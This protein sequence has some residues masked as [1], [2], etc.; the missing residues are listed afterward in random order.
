MF[1]YDIPKIFTDDNT[2][3]LSAGE[4]AHMNEELRAAMTAYDP[5]DPDYIEYEKQEFERILK[6]HGGI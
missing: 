2:E 5:D 6:V 3:G 4:L 1:T